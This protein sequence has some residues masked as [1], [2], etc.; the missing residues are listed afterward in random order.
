MKIFLSYAS[1]DKVIADQT[2]LALVGG[3]HDVFFDKESMPPGCDYRTRIRREVERCDIFV[4]LI[5]KYSVASG[6]FTIT[7]LRYAR[8]N[9][10]YPKNRVLPVRVG[11]V[12]WDMIPSYLTAISVFE[13]EGNVPSEVL[14]AVSR[15]GQA[16]TWCPKWLKG[17][18]FL[19]AIILVGSVIVAV[20]WPTVIEKV[21]PYFVDTFDEQ[22]QR[23][24][25]N[26]QKGNFA[27]ASKQF[28]SAADDVL[29]SGTHSS[30]LPRLVAAAEAA[31]GMK[32]GIDRCAQFLNE[33][34]DGKKAGLGR[35]IAAAWDNANKTYPFEVK[36]ELACKK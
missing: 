34:D 23:A 1:E 15:I 9:W 16:R 19:S 13:P 6:S 5:S 2:N 21:R 24:K 29:P 12:A 30:D 4:F 27:V 17:H 33:T 31:A 8:N 20:A 10:P 3:G 36:H 26:Y 22:V 14:M 35:E 7:E 25:E 18:P 11:D 28:A 32:L